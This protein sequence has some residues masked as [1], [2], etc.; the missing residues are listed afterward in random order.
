MDGADDR[1]LILERDD[2]SLIRGCGL[3]YRN[4]ID[5]PGRRH[6]DDQHTRR[7]PRGLFAGFADFRLVG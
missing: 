6:D 4:G 5:A 2:A 1:R 7:Q 3:A